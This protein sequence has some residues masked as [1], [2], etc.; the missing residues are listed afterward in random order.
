MF[1]PHIAGNPLQYIVI[2]LSPKSKAIVI[3]KNISYI[4]IYSD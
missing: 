4:L 2:V 1:I 3:D